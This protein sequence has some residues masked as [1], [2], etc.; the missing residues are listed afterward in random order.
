MANNTLNVCKFRRSLS[1]KKKYPL[2]FKFIFTK[3]E[4]KINYN[5]E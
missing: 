1:E 2:N 3:K 4:K 5:Y